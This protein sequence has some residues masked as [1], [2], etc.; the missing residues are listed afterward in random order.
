M[1]GLD[2][3]EE[4]TG[5]KKI[6]IQPHTGSGITQAAATLQTNY[7]TVSSS[8]KKEAGKFIF[9]VEIPSNTTA[10]VY[11]P[12]N[13]AASITESGKALNEIKEIQA[14]GAEGDYIII[15]IGS[16]KYH[17]EVK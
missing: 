8:W 6:K 4:Y 11:I 9:D 7:G 2:T 12:A 5:Y 15:R 17:F 10:T 16:G 14:G 3:D 1:A 13:N